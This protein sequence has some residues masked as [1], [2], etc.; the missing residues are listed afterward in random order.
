M[1]VFTEE[2]PRTM[3]KKTKDLPKLREAVRGIALGEED[4]VVTMSGLRR[5]GI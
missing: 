3:G 4:G 5:K 2:I 1:Y